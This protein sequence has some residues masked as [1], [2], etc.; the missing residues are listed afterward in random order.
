MG[1]LLGGLL[2]TQQQM[3]ML[4]NGD[5]VYVKDATDKGA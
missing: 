3:N 1:A 4:W 2:N 5:K